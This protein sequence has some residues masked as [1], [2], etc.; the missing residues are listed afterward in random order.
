MIHAGQDAGTSSSQLALSLV[1]GGWEVDAVRDIVLQEVRNP[2][3]VFN[4]LGFGSSPTRHLFDY[5]PDA[6]TILNAGQEVQLTGSALPRNDDSFEQ[7]ITPIYPGRLEITSG[8]G[9]VVL[10]N[11]VTLFPSPQGDLRITTSGGG[12]LFGKKPGDLVQLVM[13]DSGK[14]QYKAAGDFGSNDHAAIPVQLD[15]FNPMRLDIS[16]DLTGVLIGS[17]K[18]AQI[19]VGGNMINSRFEG[20]NLHDGDVTSIHVTGDISNRSEFTT[21]TVSAPPDFTVFDLL[22]PPLPSLLANLPNQFYYDSA[23]KTLTFQGRMTSDQLQTLLN[24]QVASF[25]QYGQ[26]L[27]DAQGN[28]LTHLGTF[29]GASAL[30]QLFANSQDIPL[31]PDTGYRIGG[32]GTFDITAHNLD[33][34]STAGIVSQ[35]PAANHAL[36]NYFTHGANINVD[37]GGNLDMFSTTI[38]SLNGGAISVSANGSINVGSRIFHGNDTA[39]RGIFTV[40]PSDVTVIAGGDINVNGSRIAAYDGGKVTIESLNGNVDAGTGGLGSTP[41]EKIYVD[42]VTRAVETYTPTIPGSGILATTFPPSLDPRFPPSR[43]QVGNILVETPL[44]NISTGSGGITQVPLNG[45]GNRLGTVTLRAGTK[46]ANGNVVKLGSI[47]A[48]GSGVIGST[49]HLDASGQISGVVVAR[50][51]LQISAREA[52]NVTALAQ[53]NA[54]I[55]SGETISGTIIGIGS[56]NVSGA[57]VDASLLSQNI[58]ASGA[59]TSDRIGFAQGTAANSTSQGFQKDDTDRTVAATKPTPEEEELRKKAAPNQPKLA[60]PLGRVTIIGPKD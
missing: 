6:Y 39:A 54:A 7:G 48:S 25:D 15:N 17:P 30:Q 9:G 21:V 52:V 20:Q 51:D 32:G 37:L 2:N 42:P 24:L 34:G 8:S 14:T 38:S 29:T 22:Y 16:G 56:V 40:D 23:A 33:L 55:S 3:G 50:A 44:G 58:A 60:R 18:A 35:G 46:D 59:I 12:G 49:V 11:D 28:P 47:D 27:L 57:V 5:S 13:S 4:N 1:S 26:P 31:N 43:N 45:I 36:A 19:N 53:G 10:G 41:V